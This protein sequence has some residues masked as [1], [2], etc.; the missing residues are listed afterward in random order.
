VR[1][2]REKKGPEGR[3]S[4]SSL[5]Q[6]ASAL[7]NK[8]DLTINLISIR[9]LDEKPKDYQ[10]NHDQQNHGA[11]DHF[12]RNSTWIQNSVPLSTRPAIEQSISALKTYKMKVTP[13]LHELLGQREVS[14]DI[15]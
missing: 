8:L 11:I 1:S 2:G 7:K 10:Q 13:H 14:S 5:L 3:D 15:A 4:Q 6:K 9:K 12:F